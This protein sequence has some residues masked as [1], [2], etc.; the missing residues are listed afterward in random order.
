MMPLLKNILIIILLPG[1]LF[2]YCIA[3]QY[4]TP[5]IDRFGTIVRG[6]TSIKAIALVFTGHEFADGGEDV[7]KTLKAKK[8]P[9]SF[10]FTGDFYLNPSFSKLIYQL[11]NDGHYLGAH[12]HRHLLYA[13]W[14]KRDSTLVSEVEFKR[15][16][17]ENYAALLRFGINRKD[18][19]Y[20]L[21]P[22]EW[23]NSDIV[24]WTNDMDLTL[25]NFS[26][27][28]RSNADYTYP[29]MGS[30]YVSSEAIYHSII[31]YENREGMNG[32]ILLIHIGTDPRRKDKLYNLL[33]NLIDDMRLKGYE[34]QRVDQLLR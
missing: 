31:N 30:R 6:D 8:V 9:A 17:E 7:T 26:S 19:Q 32:F 3:Q 15:D 25:I 23:Y 21:P 4:N 14:E 28:T 2:Q 33:G 22:Y 16:L 24:K 10:F 12:S 20:F 13:D 5:V 29:E 11:K 27:G 34:F 1:L 18:A